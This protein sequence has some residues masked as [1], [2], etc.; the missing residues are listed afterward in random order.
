MHYRKLGIKKFIMIDNASSDGTMKFLMKQRDAEVYRVNEKFQSSVKE[1]W[2]NQIFAL[3]GFH[4]WYLIVD[5][6]ELITWPQLGRK[7]FMIW[8]FFF[9]KTDSIDLWHLC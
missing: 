9:K 8:S 4:R 6:D 5:A 2:I 7:H 3:Y 1:G